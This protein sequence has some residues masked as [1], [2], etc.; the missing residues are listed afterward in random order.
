MK[1]KWGQVHEK[2]ASQEAFGEGRDGGEVG[3]WTP[4]S[5]L[6][7]APHPSCSHTLPP[8]LFLAWGNYAR[9]WQS[10]AQVH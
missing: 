10:I 6:P 2:E 5:R 4:A 7:I 9:P 8:S 3:D 1:Q